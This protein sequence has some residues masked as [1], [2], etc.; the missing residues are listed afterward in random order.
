MTKVLVT[1]GSGFIGRNIVE[2]LKNKFSV[3]APKRQELDLLDAH[4][5]E[6]FLSANNFDVVIHAS[7]RGVS[8]SEQHLQNVFETNRDMF[9]NLAAH[10]DKF[11]KMLFLAPGL[12]TASKGQ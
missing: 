3:S 1:G 10:S 8:R 4:A 9:L 7:G 12:N 6:E 11:G 5:V 2:N